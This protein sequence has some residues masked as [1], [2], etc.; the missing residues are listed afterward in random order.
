MFSK[1]QKVDGRNKGARFGTTV[2]ALGDLDK[3][4]FAGKLMPYL[5]VTTLPIK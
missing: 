5:T 2:V 4:G 3:D 1:A